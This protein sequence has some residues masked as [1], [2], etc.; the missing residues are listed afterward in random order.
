MMAVRINM[1]ML[2]R[3]IYCKFWDTHIILLYTVMLEHQYMVESLLM[4]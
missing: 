3:Y 1:D 2:L 4:V